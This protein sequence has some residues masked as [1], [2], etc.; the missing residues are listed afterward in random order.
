MFQGSHA[1]M[2][3]KQLPSLYSAD[4][5]FL[6]FFFFFFFFFVKWGLTYNLALGDTML[7]FLYPLIS[8]WDHYIRF[9]GPLIVSV[10][11]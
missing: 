8:K 10:K 6:F 7:R 1:W 9:V 3:V 4:S 2:Y 11:P 5:F